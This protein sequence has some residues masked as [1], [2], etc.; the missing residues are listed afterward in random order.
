MAQ[1]WLSSLEFHCPIPLDIQTRIFERK[2]NDLQIH[3]DLATIRTPIRQ[4]G[5]WFIKEVGV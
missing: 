3:L 2:N 4:P 1:F 5:E